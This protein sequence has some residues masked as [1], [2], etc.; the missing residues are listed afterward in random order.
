[1]L[2][3]TPRMWLANGGR[4]AVILNTEG[5]DRTLEGVTEIKTETK[6]LAGSLV[7]AGFKGKVS[8]I[9]TPTKVTRHAA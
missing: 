9:N 3:K 6:A 5:I 2:W 4:G 7:K 8:F 1:M